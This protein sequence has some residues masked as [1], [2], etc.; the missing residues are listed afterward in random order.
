MSLMKGLWDDA[1]AECTSICA[2][3]LT[4]GIWMWLCMSSFWVIKWG[5]VRAWHV[6]IHVKGADLVPSL[7]V[8]LGKPPPVCIKTQAPRN[9]FSQR[10]K[11]QAASFCLSRALVWQSL[12]NLT[13]SKD[14][15][16]KPW[17][18]RLHTWV[19]CP[20]LCSLAG[21]K[22]TTPNA[23]LRNHSDFLHHTFS[24]TGE[25]GAS[26]VIQS[27]LSFSK[28]CWKNIPPSGILCS[29]CRLLVVKFRNKLQTSPK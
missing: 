20:Q 25:A 16:R 26:K 4:Q 9:A 15:R 18:C 2:I 19:S 11:K 8:L 6:R 1:S 27:L 24:L 7:P 23:K 28:K 5:R 10:R 13:S 22:T 29:I 21:A 3:L 12:N 17:S 14:L